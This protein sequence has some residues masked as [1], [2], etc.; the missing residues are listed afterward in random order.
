MLERLIEVFQA[1][2]ADDAVRVV[3][4]TGRGRAFCAGADLSEGAGR[5]DYRSI[6]PEEHRDQGGKVT[7][8]AHACRKPII[9][10][11]NG[12][13]A[14][15]G[16]SFQLGFDIRLAARS[17]RI[18]FV[19]AR[20]GIVPEGVSSWFLPRLVGMARALDW[21]S[22]G[23]LVDAEEAQAAGLFRSLHE[24]D[25]VQP[26]AFALAREIADNTSAVS[27]AAIRR[28]LWRGL[29]SDEPMEAHLLESRMMYE[30]GASADAREGVE[31]FVQKRPPRFLDRVSAAY[32]ELLR[33][34][35]D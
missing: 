25:E 29:A 13:A 32:P 34:S 30:R 23:R 3:V 6:G 28:M 14:G 24:P 12:A 16:A 7:L 20:R 1:A 22:T 17:A 18:G 27:V 15:F 19:Y 21:M 26:A 2:D 33:N 11:I 4:V 9:G 5:F 31:S 35:A 8:A 10:A